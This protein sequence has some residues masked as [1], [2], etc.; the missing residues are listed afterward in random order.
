MI[1]PE[2]K[3]RSDRV[4]IGN[5]GCL[6][7]PGVEATVPR[8]ARIELEYRDFSWK[9]CRRSLSGFTARVVQH[10]VDHLDGICR[11]GDEWRRQK[12]TTS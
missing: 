11:T 4:E 9:L 1:N 5:E 8:A 3:S 7:Y 12:D 6:S 10:E 2:I